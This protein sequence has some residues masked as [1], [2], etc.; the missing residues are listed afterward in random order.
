V[1]ARMAEAP[2]PLL[3]QPVA[4]TAGLCAVARQACW[5]AIGLDEADT[6]LVEGALPDGY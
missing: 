5:R 4:A 2:L 1:R 3:G 6:F